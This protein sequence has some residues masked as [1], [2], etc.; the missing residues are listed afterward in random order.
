MIQV[1]QAR[2]TWIQVQPSSLWVKITASAESFWARL[3]VANHWLYSWYYIRAVLIQSSLSKSSLTP[4]LPPFPVWYAS[5]VLVLL[6]SVGFLM[7]LLTCIFAKRVMVTLSRLTW[8]VSYSS[9]KYIRTI[10]LYLKKQT[11]V[12]FLI[13]T[14]KRT[15]IHLWKNKA[16]KVGSKI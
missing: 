6:W 16:L 8:T 5:L 3:L 1:R 13:L 7:Y 9:W 14:C 4:S 11:N 2:N 12:S 15:N 10:F